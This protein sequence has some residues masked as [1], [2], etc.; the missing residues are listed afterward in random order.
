MTDH[1]PSG[2]LRVSVTAEGAG[3]DEAALVARMRSIFPTGAEE[4]R[5]ERGRFEVA[6]YVSPPL[7]LPGDLGT[8]RVEPV[9]V[10]RV[11][12]WEELPPGQAIAGRLWVGPPTE[13]PDEGLLAV[14]IDRKQVFGSGGHATTVGCL[15]L[16]CELEE[17]VS[18]LDIGCGSGVLAVAAAMLGHGPVRACDDDPLAVAAARENARRNAV[19][20]EVFVADAATGELPPADLWLANLHPGPLALLLARPDAPERAIVSG[21]R[22]DDELD[23][24][25]YAVERRFERSGWLALTLRR[26]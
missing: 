18:V 17:R 2:L 22:A 23:A 10:A 19:D 1:Q 8:W 12:S 9:G 21:L 15:T 14:R 3:M 4:G 24:P 26:A 5:D 13:E 11:R 6:A 7:T 16:L 20:V 25:G